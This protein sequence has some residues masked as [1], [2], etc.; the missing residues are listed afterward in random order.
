MKEEELP[1]Y[2]RNVLKSLGSGSAI[3]DRDIT[4]ALC[5]ANCV[6]DFKDNVSC[7]MNTLISE[8]ECVKKM[9]IGKKDEESPVPGVLTVDDARQIAFETLRYVTTSPGWE[10]F[11]DFVGEELDITDETMDEA[12]GLLFSE[13]ETGPKKTECVANISEEEE[14]RRLVDRYY[15]TEE[16]I[17][18]LLGKLRNYGTDCDCGYG[19][20]VTFK[21]I[22]EGDFDEILETCVNCGGTVQ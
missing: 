18:M 14:L 1:E 3:I 5:N 21:Q 2:L 15:I 6:E 19:N 13:G 22:I 11:K 9:I 20:R 17:D 7:A 12:V 10:N 4:D 8:A 16:E